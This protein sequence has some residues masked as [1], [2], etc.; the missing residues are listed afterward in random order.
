MILSANRGNFAIEQ[1][2]VISKLLQMKYF[3]FT[4]IWIYNSHLCDFL[5]DQRVGSRRSDGSRAS[6]L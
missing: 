6:R 1:I 4:Y 3:I 2:A 5:Y